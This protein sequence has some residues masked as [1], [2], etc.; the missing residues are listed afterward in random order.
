MV[1]QDHLQLHI[2]IGTYK[3]A[4][5]EYIFG[6]GTQKIVPEDIGTPAVDPKDTKNPYLKIQEY[7]PF[8]VGAEEELEK[9][10][11]IMLSFI[12]QQFE[13]TDEGAIFKDAVRLQ[14]QA[15]STT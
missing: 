8:H 3:T 2:S 12:L 15:A 6:P 4:Y 10:L 13:R 11:T 5:L 1:A 14:T 7:G 9:F